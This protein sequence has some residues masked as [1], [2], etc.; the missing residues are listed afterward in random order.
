MPGLFLKAANISGV[1]SACLVRHCPGTNISKA[2]IYISAVVK[3]KR[4]DIFQPFLRSVSQRSIISF[5]KARIYVCPC[6]QQNF[7]DFNVF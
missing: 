5:V 1:L 2:R 3:E 7:Y 4:S 6:V